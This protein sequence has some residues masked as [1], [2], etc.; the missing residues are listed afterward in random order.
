MILSLS[1]FLILNPDSKQDVGMVVQVTRPV[2][3]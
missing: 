1:V 2:R 3:V